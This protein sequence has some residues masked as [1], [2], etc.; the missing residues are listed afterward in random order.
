M[1]QIIAQITVFI[2]DSEKSEYGVLAVWETKEDQDAAQVQ[3]ADENRELVGALGVKS[4]S[5][6]EY[7]VYEPKI[8]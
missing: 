5:R 7:E 4:F 8:I 3:T 6:R 2:V 1:S